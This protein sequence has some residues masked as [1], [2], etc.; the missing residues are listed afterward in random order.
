MRDKFKL[1]KPFGKHKKG[2]IFESFGGLVCGI[3]DNKTN[4]TIRFDDK[5][6]FTLIK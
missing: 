2:K 6:Y 5:N 4:Q 1:L 3:T